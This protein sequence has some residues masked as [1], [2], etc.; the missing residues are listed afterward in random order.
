[1]FDVGTILVIAGLGLIAGTI[2]GMLGLGGSNIMIPG[3]VILFGQTTRQGFNQHL[4]QAAA[5]IVNVCV[6]VAATWRHYQA[7]AIVP[8]VIRTM[9]PAAIAAILLG[10][11]VSNRSAFS[12][13]QGPI[14]LGRVMACFLVYVIAMNI[15]RMFRQSRPVDAPL[16]LTYVTTPRSATV[17]TVM[18]FFAGL[19]GVGGGGIA[20]P[21]QQVILNLRLRNC[22]ANSAAVMCFSSIVGATYKNA[23]LPA[24]GVAIHDSLMIAALLAP[25]AI[26]GATIGGKLT[27]VLPVRTVRFVFIL[28]MIAAAWKMAAI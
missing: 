20:T 16:D 7:G 27:H 10:V 8:K 28:L 23:T 6:A 1:M 2:G 17:G 19:V 9:L 5:M 15:R 13:T 12:G 18:G 3:L 11:W 21:L 22:I 25:T 26:F 24:H 4:Y 14:L